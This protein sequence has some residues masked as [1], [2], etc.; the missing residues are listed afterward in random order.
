M[1]KKRFRSSVNVNHTRSFPGAD[2]G[3]DHELLMMTF[4]LRLKMNIKPTNTRIKYDLEKMKDPTEANTF[5]AKI[6]GTFAQLILHENENNDI[7]T[8]ITAMNIAVTETAKEIL[9]KHRRIKLLQIS[10]KRTEEKER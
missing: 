5:Q 6:C 3:S 1:V 2:L 9:G 10:S 4:R 8:M 7:Y